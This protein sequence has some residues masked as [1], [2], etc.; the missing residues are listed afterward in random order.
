[1]LSKLI[2]YEFRA[3]ARYYLPIYAGL[4]L[5]SLLTCLVQAV[6]ASELFTVL[7]VGIYVLFAMALLVITAVV[8]VARFYRNLLGHEGYLMFTLPVT[9]GQN[10]LAKLIPALVWM[11]GSGLLGALTIGFMVA[12]SPLEV[13]AE[14]GR[15]ISELVKGLPLMDI[16]A[17]HILG[18][19]PGFILIILASL[20]S[21]ILTVYMCLGIGQL[22][23]E[24]KFLCSIGAY[25]G[26]GV[27][28]QIVSVLLFAL[29]GSFDTIP[30]WLYALGE[31]VMLLGEVGIVY[32]IIYGLVIWCLACCLVVYLIT[33]WLLTKHLNL[34]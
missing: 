25:L 15:A 27:V 21:S 3:T 34:A 6:Q 26:L 1:M 32:L 4:L 23:N 10:I 9:A 7:T 14:L 18:M 29:L 8:I 24:H 13:F 2:K 19:A 16:S 5:L 22:A 28:G 20:A 11:V 30:A 17:W 31:R 33:R 12:G